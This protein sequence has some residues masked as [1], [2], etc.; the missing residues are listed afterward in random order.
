MQHS[1]SDST[2]IDYFRSEGDLLA[3]ETELLGGV[4]RDILADQGRVTNKAIIL[5]L[6]AE[7]ECTSDV[8]RMDVL[9]KTLEIVVGRTPDDT[10]F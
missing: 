6:I 8:V 7:L 9:R 5:Y 1:S 10:G 2:I 4:I 3:P